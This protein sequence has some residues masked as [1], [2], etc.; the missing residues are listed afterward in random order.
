MGGF[1]YSAAAALVRLQIAG[2][3]DAHEHMAAHEPRAFHDLNAS[4]RAIENACSRLSM[5]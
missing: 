4:L 3:V 2:D 5:S 1:R